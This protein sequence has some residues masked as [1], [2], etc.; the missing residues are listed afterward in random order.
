MNTS[1]SEVDRK[2]AT[3]DSFIFLAIFAALT[4]ALLIEL[5]LGIKGVVV[6]STF[7][8]IIGLFVLAQLFLAN[9]WPARETGQDERIKR[10]DTYAKARAWDIS[11]LLVWVI[12]LGTNFNVF[13]LDGWTVAW[14]LLMVLTFIWTFFRW[15][16]NRKGDAE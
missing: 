9:R 1:M 2:K 16:Y 11:L 12:V 10:I 4:I 7:I 8:L 3:R 5:Y 14:V 6:F 15:Y 13:S